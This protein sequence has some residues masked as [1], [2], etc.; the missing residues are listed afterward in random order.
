VDQGRQPSGE[1]DAVQ[2]PPAPVQRGLV[3][4]SAIAYTGEPVAAAGAAATDWEP[5]AD[6]LDA[7]AGQDAR[8]AGQIH[9]LLLAA[10]GREP[11]DTA[12]GGHAATDSLT[13]LPAG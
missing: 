8:P 9:P 12:F 10:A 1:G 3:V 11:S 6:Q 5:V 13:A 7:T 2:L 4:V